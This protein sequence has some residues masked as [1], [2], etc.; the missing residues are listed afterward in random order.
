[1]ESLGTWRAAS[2]VAA[3]KT[4]PLGASDTMAY[5]FFLHKNGR[6]VDGLTLF[7]KNVTLHFA[8]QV[9]CA[10]CYSYV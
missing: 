3:G 4:E 8:G 1:V 7:T 2:C 6:I 9:E 5:P 10:I